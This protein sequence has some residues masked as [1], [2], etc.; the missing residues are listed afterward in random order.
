MII[1]NESLIMVCLLEI[2]YH[3]SLFGSNIVYFFS[4]TL[5]KKLLL[6]EDEI[7]RRIQNTHK[8]DELL[9]RRR[10]EK[11]ETKRD[12]TQLHVALFSVKICLVCTFVHLTMDW[13][14]AYIVHAH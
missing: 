13:Y 4:L 5:F 14:S 9:R 6:G 11:N 10:S 7:K 1:I 12:E 2:T 3:L 8:S